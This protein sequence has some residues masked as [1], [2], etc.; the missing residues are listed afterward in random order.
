MVA[1]SLEGWHGGEVKEF[2]N[3]ENYIMPGQVISLSWNLNIDQDGTTTPVC[4]LY[5]DVSIKL[6]YS[7]YSTEIHTRFEDDPRNNPSTYIFDMSL[8]CNGQKEL[9]PFWYVNKAS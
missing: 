1:Y 3:P 6:N 7:G 8:G 4:N 2:Q 9:V 5:K